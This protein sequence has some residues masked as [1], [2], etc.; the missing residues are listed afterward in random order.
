MVLAISRLL[1][2][3]VLSSCATPAIS[4]PSAASFSCDTSWAWA[5]LQLAVGF[6][7]VE[8]D[9]AVGAQGAENHALV[10]P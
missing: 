5:S 3:G 1:P 2:I 7:V 10:S 4:E 8:R 6:G 9:G